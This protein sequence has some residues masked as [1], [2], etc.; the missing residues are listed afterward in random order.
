[1]A[2][3]VIF[4]GLRTPEIAL[5]P[6]AKVLGFNVDTNLFQ[7]NHPMPRLRRTTALASP[8]VVLSKTLYISAALWAMNCSSDSSHAG[9]SSLN[10][11][12]AN[13]SS[14]HES[15]MASMSLPTFTSPDFTKLLNLTDHS[16]KFFWFPS[17][18]VRFL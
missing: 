18:T 5:I 6:E 12:A 11:F 3:F 4:V 17:N 7:A 14:V 2:A 15:S 9:S 10:L 16:S 1:M 8:V 13:L